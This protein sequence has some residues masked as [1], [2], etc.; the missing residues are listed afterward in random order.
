MKLF[1]KPY[2]KNALC[3]AFYTQIDGK[4]PQVICH[5]KYVLFIAKTKLKKG[6][7][8]YLKS[9]GITTFRKM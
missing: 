9:N 5:R 7:I 4:V 2:G 6:I 3:Q 8:S 1:W